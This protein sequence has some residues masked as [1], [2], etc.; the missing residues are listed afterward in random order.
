MSQSTTDTTP[1]PHC[2][3]FIQ[4]QITP[5]LQ[6]LLKRQKTGMA[7]KMDAAFEPATPA[8]HLYLKMWIN[9]TTVVDHSTLTQLFFLLIHV[10]QRVKR[11]LFHSGATV[12]A[13]Q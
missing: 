11:E 13:L 10:P 12:S 7:T 6:L 2:T 9:L 1:A 8:Q 5:E 4:K 3:S